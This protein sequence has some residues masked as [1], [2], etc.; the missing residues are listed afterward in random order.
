V[1]VCV[2]SFGMQVLMVIGYIL[3]PR[4]AEMFVVR[5][6]FSFAIISVNRARQSVVLQ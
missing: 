1:C 3:T 4:F 5:A 6:L 2:H